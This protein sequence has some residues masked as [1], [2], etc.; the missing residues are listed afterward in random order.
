MS[1]FTRKIGD[2]KVLQKQLTTDGFLQ[3][4]NSDLIQTGRAFLA[5]RNDEATIYYNGN[6]LCNLPGSK[7]YE[8][9]VYNHY[10]PIT[11]SRTLSKKQKKELYTIGQWRKNIG[12][13]KLSF[14][15][16]IKE[17]LD[18]LEKESSPESLQASRFYR[19][20]PLNTKT[21]PEIVLLDI[22]AAFSSSD[23]KTDRIDLVFYH[24]KDRRLMFVEVKHLSDPRLDP[25]GKESADVIDQLKRYKDRLETEVQQITSQY[26]NSIDYYN[27]LSG[28]NLPHVSLESL[29]LLGLLLVEFNQSAIKKK[30]EVQEMITRNGFKSY[31]IG[32]TSNVTEVSTIAAIYTVLKKKNMEGK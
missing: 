16:V 14:E 4:I 17:I 23:E 27:T 29:P 19:F 26:N 12:S 11:R 28:G 3:A 1:N 10:L 6:Q 31:A 15:S 25:K 22:E 5:F 32:D 7:G 20:S 21:T 2:M 8:P 13:K 24:R 30:N 18:N 9:M